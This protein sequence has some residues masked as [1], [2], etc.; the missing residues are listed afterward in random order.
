MNLEHPLYPVAHQRLLDDLVAMF[1]TTESRTVTFAPGIYCQWAAYGPDTGLHVELV[2]NQFLPKDRQ[3]SPVDIALLHNPI[4][5]GLDQVNLNPYWRV[6]GD[7]FDLF[8]IAHWVLVALVDA[9]HL[10]EYV[11][12]TTGLLKVPVHPPTATG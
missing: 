1:N 5:Q 12:L 11:E 3:L 6:V 10:P 7:P 8:L 9:H 2:S 4:L